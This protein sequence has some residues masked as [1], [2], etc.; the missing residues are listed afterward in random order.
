MLCLLGP[1]GPPRA[2][3]GAS[4][5]M[6]SHLPLFSWQMR[7]HYVPETPQRYSS[8][9]NSHHGPQ[10]EARRSGER[11]PFTEEEDGIPR[12]HA[13][14]PGPQ[15]FSVGSLGFESRT[16]DPR[17]LAH[18]DLSIPSEAPQPL[19][20]SDLRIRARCLFVYVFISRPPEGVRLERNPSFNLLCVP[21]S[22][23]NAWHTVQ[24]VNKR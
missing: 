8:S 12:E 22:W 4:V 23:D 21:C 19:V 17:A 11:L 20:F 6:S 2:H 1:P 7:P 3:A 5:K 18:S 9:L 14:C 15:N 10:R 24:S 13:P 16:L